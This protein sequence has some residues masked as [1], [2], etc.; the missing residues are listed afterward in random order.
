MPSSP[1]AK[2]PISSA[3]PKRFLVARS[4]RSSWRRSP[5]RYSTVSTIC[6]RTLG[7]AIEPSFVTCPTRKTGTL[8][9]LASRMSLAADSRTWV[10][11][12]A[13]PSNPA[14]VTVWIESMIASSGASPR[15][16][17]QMASRSFSARS[18]M[19]G[20]R[21]LRRSARIRTCWPDSSP[22]T[23]RTLPRLATWAAACIK[24]VDLPTPGSPPIRTRLPGTTPPPS[25][26]L[27]SPQ[28][29]L[30]RG[31]SSGAI[32]LRGIARAGRSGRDLE[33]LA[34]FRTWN[35][36]SVFHAPQCGHWP[37]QRRLSPPHSVQTKVIVDL[38]MQR[39]YPGL[40]VGEG[41]RSFLQ[42]AGVG[43]CERQ[44]AAL[45][46]PRGGVAPSPL[47]GEG[48]P[49]FLPRSPG[50]VAPA[51]S[52]RA[53]WGDPSSH[54]PPNVD[55]SISIERILD[56][57]KVI[58]PVFLHTPQYECEP[59]SARIGVRTVLKVES[60][61]HIRP[62]QGRGADYLLHRLAAPEQGFVCAS[63]GNFGQGMAYACRK[64]G[65]PLTVFAARGAN[66][67]K[68]ERMRALGA[69]V[70][71]QGED[72]DQAKDAAK[73]SASQN[74]QTYIEDGRLGAIA[75]GAATMAVELSNAGELDAIFVPLGNGSLVNGI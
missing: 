52:A 65:V 11:L 74:D 50:K 25:T 23:Y 13:L 29:S 36:W 30:V 1:M 2:T 38:G 10:T 6:S 48:G 12:P 70:T 3:E 8:I 19:P 24:R 28:A 39:L 68:V 43:T 9:S 34:A 33:S 44:D 26:R 60:V 21:A 66:P 40:P 67:L 63:A 17:S 37:A 45:T 51:R 15:I 35:S 32:S 16:A 71:L 72:F 22:E 75:E 46:Y 31:E 54:Y 14:S 57:A 47:A 73:Q 41:G 20:S 56:A 69:K 59:L 7:P 18:R 64:R 61:N 27:S 5:S 49:A 55:A 62:F 4:K 58:D 42:G 53:G